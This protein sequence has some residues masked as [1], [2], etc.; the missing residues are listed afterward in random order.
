MLDHI[1]FGASRL[2]RDAVNTALNIV[3]TCQNTIDAI[4]QTTPKVIEEPNLESK[5]VEDNWVK[6]DLLG[7]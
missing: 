2:I 6:V 4:S 5:D 1:V 7:Q 3:E